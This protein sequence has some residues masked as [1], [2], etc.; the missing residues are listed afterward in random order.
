MIITLIAPPLMDYVSGRLMPISMDSV[1]TCPPYGIYL[2]ATILRK[3]GH[4]VTIIDLIAQGSKELTP[5]WPI[6]H[7]SNL[8]GIGATSL[9]W[10]TAKDCITEIRRL[11]PYVPIVLGGIHPSLFDKYVLATTGANF[12]IRGEGE[13][14]LPQLCRTLQAGGDFQA[15]PNLTFKRW[16]GKIIRNT[17]APQLSEL[18][19]ARLP[20][21]DFSAI[22]AGIY[23]GLSIESSRGCPF[24]CAF[25]S[26][27]H[28]KTWR[29]LETYCFVDKVEQILPYTALTTAGLIQI[30]D[31]EFS[32]KTQRAIE[33]AKEFTRRNL[34]LNIVFDSRANDLLNEEYVSSI[35]PYARQFLVGA[36]CGYNEG[37]EKV[38]K[39]TTTEKLE[40][41]AKL[42]KKYNIAQKADFSF[43]L[44]LPWETKT[45]VMKTINF[46]HHLYIDYGVRVLLQ[47]YCQI[48]G[49]HLWDEQKENEVL[50]EAHYDDYGFFRNHYLF[51]TGVRLRPSEIHEVY[52]YI[53]S[54]KADAKKNAYGMDMIEPSIPYPIL[55]LYP[56]VL[57][58]M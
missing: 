38:G 7:G 30:I 10:P 26:T 42:L 3:L 46:A 31:D 55:Q 48:P 50:N 32:L 11:N 43:V 4:Q 41:A 39:G 44:G 20:V 21:P 58:Q 27:V 22:P 28:R 54:L 34:K 33:I 51:R 16:D 5:Y 35:A 56:E 13:V 18:E 23:T 57:K 29:S 49:S 53:N 25:C 17:M 37:L 24:D 8:V 14:A 36:E 15:I 12:V 1:R 6:I 19:L 52:N 2:L 9:S 47:W 40:Q 45:E